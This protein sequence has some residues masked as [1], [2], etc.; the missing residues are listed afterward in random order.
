[1]PCICLCRERHRGGIA[2][3]FRVVHKNCVSVDN[4]LDNL[5]LVPTSVAHKWMVQHRW[6]AQAYQQKRQQ[7]QQ[8]QREQQEPGSDA[9]KDNGGSSNSSSSSD[10][11]S[12]SQSSSS[13]RRGWTASPASPPVTRSSASSSSSSSTHKLVP[14]VS[15]NPEHS[16]YWIA[17]QQLP[18]ESMEEVSTISVDE[19][20]HMDRALLPFR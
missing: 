14:E 12:G 9:S 8:Q 15:E 7:Q 10:S 20:K 6:Q 18:Q 4:R 11:D 16:I 5:V 1:M 2:P 3:G 19:R 13:S 17:I